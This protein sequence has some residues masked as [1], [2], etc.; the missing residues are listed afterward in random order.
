[1]HKSNFTLVISLIMR[2]I[3]VLFFLLIFVSCKS[4]NQLFPS[5]DVYLKNIKIDSIQLDSFYLDPMVASYVGELGISND[6]LYFAD[7]K[8]CWVFLFDRGGHLVERKLGQGRGPNELPTNEICGVGCFEN[9]WL[10]IGS[11][12]DCHIYD[13]GFNFI[14]SYRLGKGRRDTILSY[15]L[16]AV[17]TLSYNNLTVREYDQILYMNIYSE[18]P[19]LNYIEN[20]KSYFDK[21]KILFNID[22]MTGRV[23]KLQGGYPP[24]YS[25]ESELLR[26]YSNINYDIN[27]DNGDF[28]I[29]YEADSLIYC[30][31]KDYKIKSAF[32]VHGINMDM[33]YPKLTDEEIISKYY[34]ERPLY[35]YY[36][37]IKYLP[38]AD[39]IIRT[40]N[41]GEKY[42]S[43]GMQIYEDQVLIG[44][45]DVPKNFTV[46]GW[47]KPYIY[48][49][50]GI[51]EL[52]E[53]IKLYKFLYEK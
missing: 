27:P 49:Y 37:N 10:F 29:S 5:S 50:C 48:A 15:D 36:K 18:A 31:D 43:D 11:G 30:Y 19:G 4:N 3:S 8:F 33:K 25:K 34:T 22:F 53:Q 14:Q 20:S 28:Y 47:V 32:G 46:I 24:L 13:R 41:K 35:A 26:L 45:V 51:D 9:F 39:L 7:S 16:P 40:Y 12:N 42:L 38:E 6:S 23:I 17:Y 52:N 1:M 44:D 2:N 21:S